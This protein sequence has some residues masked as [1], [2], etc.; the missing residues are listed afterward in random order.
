MKKYSIQKKE[1]KEQGE[2][3]SRLEK[4][5]KVVLIT[6]YANCYTIPVKW[7]G[8]KHWLIEQDQLYAMWNNIL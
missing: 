6:F 5:T 2:F 1:G 7:K 4:N 8:F 3:K